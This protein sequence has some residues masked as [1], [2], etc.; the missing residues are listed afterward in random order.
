MHYEFCVV[1]KPKNRRDKLGGV[2]DNVPR[3]RYIRDS[4]AEQRPLNFRGKLIGESATLLICWFVRHERR[5]G[6]C[7]NAGIGQPVRQFVSSPYEDR[8]SERAVA[9]H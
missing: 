4:R 6:L 7:D 9:D 8:S 1:Q 3:V 5:T 2:C